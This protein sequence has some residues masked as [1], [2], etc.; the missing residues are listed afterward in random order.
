MSDLQREILDFGMRAR[1]ASRTLARAKSPQK[2]EA[3]HAMADELI[4]RSEAILTANESDV[5]R[6]KSD[7][8]SAAM[9][10]RLTL[11]SARLKSMAD[12]IRQVTELDDPVGKIITEWTRPNGLRIVKVR[13][14]IGVIGIIYESRPN[15]TSDAAVLCLKTGNAAILRGGSESILSNIAIAE[16]LQAG[17]SRAGLPG[18]QH[19]AD[20]KNGS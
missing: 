1:V 2:N 8:L 13:V 9:I 12:G 3:L 11:N 10:D 15:V 20:S 18:G 19:F 5:S 14:P 4:A 16:A 6:A 17:A 7:V